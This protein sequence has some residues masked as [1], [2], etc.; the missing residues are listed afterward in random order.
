MHLQ[1]KL[2]TRVSI[3]WI[4]EVKCTIDCALKPMYI[5][6]DKCHLVNISRQCWWY[7]WGWRWLFMMSMYI[8]ATFLAIT[9]S[10]G[11]TWQR[12]YIEYKT[13]PSAMKPL[14]F[15]YSSLHKEASQGGVWVNLQTPG[16]PHNLNFFLIHRMQS[17]IS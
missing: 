16:T 10:Q 8:S 2:A 11:L 1:K 17:L 15:K 14:T 6:T 5:T 3:F 4:C 7:W 9:N 13:P 12:I